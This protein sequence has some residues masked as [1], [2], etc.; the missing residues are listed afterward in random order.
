MGKQGELLRAE[1]LEIMHR[2]AAPLSAYD[3]LSELQKNNDK[4]APPTVY[5]ALAALAKSG[6]VHRLESLNAYVPCQCASHSHASILSICD[7]CGVV[8]E[9]VAPALLSDLSSIIGE[10]GFVPER[11][12]IEVHGTCASCGTGEN[13]S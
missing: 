10:T 7:D 13:S 6:Q 3:L 8:E 11:H 4:M 5:R 12:V 9:K 1:V 2:R